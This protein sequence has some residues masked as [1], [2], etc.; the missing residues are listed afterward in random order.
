MP[1]LLRPLTFSA[2]LAL[3]SACP[4]KAPTPEAQV[5]VKPANPDGVPIV[6]ANDPRIVH[7]GDDMYAVESAPR[8]PAQE[9][10]PGSGR[11]DTTNGVC[12]LFAPKLPQ[13]ECC[14]FETGF[15]AERIKAICGHAL[16]MGESLQQSCGYFFLP[17]T[18][19]SSPVW[20]RASKIARE[21]VAGAAADHDQ[22]MQ[23]ITKNPQ[24]ASTPV[25]GVE[26][27][28]WSSA[29]NLHWAF[30]PGWNSVRL[31]AWRDDSCPADKMPEVLK[32]MAEAV[33][34][35]PEAPRPGLIP[36]AR[37][38]DEMDNQPSP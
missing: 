37:T 4:A 26:G 20:M 19:G 6:D 18:D 12:K 15:D 23:R 5:E 38:A 8:P 33:E 29:E 9:P 28:L 30:L 2:G 17:T 11:P 1:R 21:D 27:A 16:Y 35:H 7:D 32:L 24:F 14:P 31:V 10:A 36:I 3:C 34:P 13:P 25:P 22:R